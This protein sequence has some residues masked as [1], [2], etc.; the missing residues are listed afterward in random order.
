MTCKYCSAELE[1]G[2]S[3]CPVCGK[4]N[5]PEE[6][7]EETVVEE[8]V[9]EEAV[10]EA[11]IAEEAVSEAETVAEQEPVPEKTKKAKKTKKASKTTKIVLSAIGGALALG[12]LVCA[13]L[14]LLG[15]RFRA[16][17]PTYKNK[18]TV[19][20]SKA[21]RQADKVVAEVEG[22]ELTNA[23]LQLFYSVGVMEFLSD[24]SGSLESV[25]GLNYTKPLYDQTS[26]FDPDQTW[27]QFFVGMAISN[28]HQAA[29]LRIMGE[30]DGYTMDASILAS[31]D[32]LPEELETLASENGYDSVDALLK[33]DLGAAVTLEGYL[34]YFYDYYY[35]LCYF[36]ERLYSLEPTLEEMLTYYEENATELN[37]AG[38][39]KSDDKSYDVRHILI[40]VGT[41][42]G[43]DGTSSSTDADWATCLAEAEKILKE[44]KNGE[45]TEES[46]AALA[47]EYSTD[48]G[49]SSNGG[50]YSGLTSST[51]F[52]QEFKDWYL[53]ENRQVG[54]TGLVKSDYGYHIM[55][56]SASEE[57]WLTDLESYMLTERTI[58]MVQEAKE[59]Y[60]MD[61][62]YRKVV[63]GEM[64][65]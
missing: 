56:F 19:S 31:I 50:L 64:S 44:W 23:E 25:Y 43:E 14:L 13:V 17:E 51:S 35:S 38:I 45:A 47:Q 53:D 42:E 61:V 1:E 29:V 55:Y 9:S 2:V 4:E 34:Q 15:F 26:Y 28:W 58:E 32:A 63:L 57:L 65:F 41:T 8:A 40:G 5:L 7:I 10:P 3:L 16:N 33:H 59:Q 37:E 24:Y 46:F 22:I 54:D 62:T 48:P 49:S 6:Q 39:T 21:Q 20:E 12:V 52:V 60:P 30:A 11:T 27:E 36:N 18:Y